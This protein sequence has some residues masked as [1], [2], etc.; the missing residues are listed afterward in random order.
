MLSCLRNLHGEWLS[1]KH[2]QDKLG[3]SSARIKSVMRRCLE[4]GAWKYD[5]YEKD[6]LLYGVILTETFDARRLGAPE[7]R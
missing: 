2:M 7:M 5:R 3:W 6:L 4:D 1:E